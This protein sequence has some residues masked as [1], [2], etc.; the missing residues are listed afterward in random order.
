MTLDTAE[1]LKRECLRPRRSSLL[2]V[3]VGVDGEVSGGG[4]V[5]GVGEGSYSGIS[6]I[7]G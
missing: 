2:A 6:S 7:L 3:E 4:G 5:V 1:I